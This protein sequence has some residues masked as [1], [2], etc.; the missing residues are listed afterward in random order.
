[1]F[2]IH[3][4][5]KNIN[6]IDQLVIEVHAYEF[7]VLIFKIA[8]CMVLNVSNPKR[9]RVVEKNSVDILITSLSVSQLMTRTL[10]SSG[11][12]TLIIVQTIR[13]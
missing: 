8:V 13:E 3:R 12:R 5:C 9:A 11:R 1:M 4:R 6:L 7:D 10:R 2:H